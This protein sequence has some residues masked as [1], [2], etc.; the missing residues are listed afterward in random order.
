MADNPLDLTGVWEKFRIRR[1]SRE[2]IVE[3]FKNGHLVKRTR[4]VRSVSNP[5]G[6]LEW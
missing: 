2:V 1:V 4:T 3:E 6:E 5:E